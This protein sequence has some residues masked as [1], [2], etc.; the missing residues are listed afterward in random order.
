MLLRCIH[1]QQRRDGFP[2]TNV[3][4][5]RDQGCIREFKTCGIIFDPELGCCHCGSL[6]EKMGGFMS[7]EV[8]LC[9]LDSHHVHLFI[10]F[11]G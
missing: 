3:N 9:E 1:E 2:W 4:V 5:C 11:F 6:R 7:V 10:S 8:C